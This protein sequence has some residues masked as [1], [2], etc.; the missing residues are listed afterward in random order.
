M[1]PAWTLPQLTDHRQAAL[2]GGNRGGTQVE[3]CALHRG[4]RTLDLQHSAAEFVLDGAAFIFQSRR[5]LNRGTALDLDIN[6][7]Q[8]NRAVR[9]H[10][11]LGRA[12]LEN[13][14]GPSLESVLLA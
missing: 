12:D 8:L 11:Q 5:L 4:L 7:V 3:Q 6:T 14:F 1:P 2:Q 13:D 9:L 10:D